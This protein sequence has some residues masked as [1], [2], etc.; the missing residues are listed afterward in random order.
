MAKEQVQIVFSADANQ[1]RQLFA[2]M[3]SGM[4]RIG[5]QTEKSTKQVDMIGISFA[6]MAAAGATAWRTLTV[7]IERHNEELRKAADNSRTYEEVI[8]RIL[9][10]A[11]LGGGD[12]GRISAATNAVAL[13]NRLG[14]EQTGAAITQLISSGFDPGE[15]MAEG[16]SADVFIRM[17]HAMNASGIEQDPRDLA[18]AASKFL[19]GTGQPLDA[20]GLQG[21]SAP[22]FNLFRNT[23]LQAAHLQNLGP[24][25]ASLTQRGISPQEQLATFSMLVDLMEPS[26]AATGFSSL[27]ARLASSGT[28]REVQR[29]LAMLG[30]KPGDVD[31]V[32]ESFG[33]VIG[34]I[35]SGAG[36]ISPDQQA[37]AF[38]LIA[39]QEH[40]KVL[41]NLTANLD[42][43]RQ[44]QQ[45]LGGTAGLNRAVATRMES[46][47]AQETETR[48]RGEIANEPFGEATRGLDEYI[49]GRAARRAERMPQTTVG[50]TLRAITD[51]LEGEGLRNSALIRSAYG[52]MGTRSADGQP[53]EIYLRTPNQTR[54]PG[55]A[56]G[57]QHLMRLDPRFLFFTSGQ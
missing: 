45:G 21:L 43:I 12:R 5:Q 3:S 7:A 1:A 42:T 17:M 49:A 56:S 10:Q 37:G 33:D 27:S 41:E 47:A 29:G 19:R 4:N 8:T 30:L 18:L 20:R 24:V 35:R 14:R 28:N 57:L 25:S 55:T 53:I 52:A 40:L 6:K 32:G 11:G 31:M 34:R 15:V 51:Y 26:V 22:L 50:Q 44:R 54:I 23:N 16:G 13:R 36:G 38:R 46:M 39:G 48:I 2:E 9:N